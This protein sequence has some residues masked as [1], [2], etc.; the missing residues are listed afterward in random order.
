MQIG[1]IF[2][3]IKKNIQLVYICIRNEEMSLGVTFTWMHTKRFNAFNDQKIII[4]YETLPTIH[5]V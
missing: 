2:N 4:P 5:L 3:K 1:C